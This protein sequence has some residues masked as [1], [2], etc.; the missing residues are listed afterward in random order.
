LAQPYFD[1][2][3]IDQYIAGK[4]SLGLAGPSC[5]AFSRPD[6]RNGRHLLRNIIFPCWWAQR[7]LADLRVAIFFARAEAADE[8][9][10][11]VTRWDAS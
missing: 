6:R 8:F 2:N 9:T 1:E 10:S 4:E 11:T 7:C 5:C 3:G